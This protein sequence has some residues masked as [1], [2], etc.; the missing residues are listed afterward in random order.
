MQH[1]YSYTKALSASRKVNW[2]VEDLIGEGKR[3][4]FTRPFLPES[5]ARTRT[6]SFLSP[7]EQLLANQIRAHGYLH[8]FGVVEEFVLPFVVDHAR[9]RLAPDDAR[10]RALLQFASEEAKHIELFKRFKAEFTRGFGS[11]CDGIGPADAIAREVLR[12][13]PLAVAIAILHIEWMTQRHYLESV[14]DQGGLDPQFK[15]LLKHHYLEEVQ[16]AKLDTLMVE[17]LAAN[18]SEAELA[19]AVEEY[20]EI[21]VFIDQGLR[22]QID[23]D[24]AAL[25]R[26]IGR[27]FEAADVERYVAVQ[28]PAL[29]WTFLGSGMTHPNVLATLEAL[30]PRARERIE[31]VAPAFC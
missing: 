17:T 24:M 5:L 21:G 14:S 13:Q 6:L 19:S 31:Q 3:L 11:S 2:Q 10:T 22:Q 12:H 28:E 25:E 15:S 30:S 7:N 9:P 1:Q 29:R 26:V 16:H 8:L 20:L 18:Q 27:R 23:L 4:D